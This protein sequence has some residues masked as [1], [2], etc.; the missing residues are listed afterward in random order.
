TNRAIP[1]YE[2]IHQQTLELNNVEI[3]ERLAESH[4]SLGHY[5]KALAYF[6]KLNSEN[7]DVLFKYGFTAAHEKR[8]DIAIHIWHKLLDLDPY[9]HTVYY[10][11]AK[12]LN[13]EG[14]MEE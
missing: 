10:E 5:D 6:E 13:E 14:R 11:L 9:Y 12:V 3:G 8:N 7:P 1:F 4:A 2:K